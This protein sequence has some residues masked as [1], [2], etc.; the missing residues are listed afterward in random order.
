MSSVASRLPPGPR[1]PL[2]GTRREL[3]GGVVAFETEIRRFD[4]M[5]EHRI[6]GRIVAPLG[7]FGAQALAAAAGTSQREARAGRVEDTLVERPLTLPRDDPTRRRNARPAAT[8]RVVIGCGTDAGWRPFEL[9]SRMGRQAP[10]RHVSGRLATAPSARDAEAT[11]LDIDRCRAR[12]ASSPVSEFYRRLAHA[13][14]ELGTEFR[15]LE[16]LWLG[17]GEALGVVRLPADRQAGA[18][19]PHPVMLDACFQVVAA[20]RPTG[21]LHEDEPWLTLG[22]KRLRLPQPFPARVIC[23]ALVQPPVD[24]DGETLKADLTWYGADGRMVGEALGVV[25]RR[26]SRSRLVA[27]ATGVE[28]LLYEVKWRNAAPGSPKVADQEQ[29]PEPGAWLLFAPGAGEAL[30][31]ARDLA[32]ALASRGHVAVLASDRRLPDSRAVRIEPLER[33]SW[34][35]ALAAVSADGPCRGVV[36]LA[37]VSGSEPEAAVGFSETAEGLLRSAQALSQASS[38]TDQEQLPPL[39]FVTRGGQM[40]GSEWARGLPG[41]LLWGLGR[42]LKCESGRSGVRLVDLDPGTP[43]ADLLARELVHADGETDIAFRGGRRLTA[44]LLPPVSDTVLPDH[45]TFRLTWNT[46]GVLEPLPTEKVKPRPLAAGEVRIAVEAAGLAFHDVIAAMGLAG[47]DQALGAEMCGRVLEVGPEVMGIS[48]GDRVVGLAR[49]SFGTEVVTGAEL[50][51]PAPPGLASVVCATLPGPFATAALAFELAGLQAGDRVLIHA[52]AGGVGHAAMQLADAAGLQ[53]LATASDPKQDYLRSLGV[54]HVF[55]SRTTAFGA[56]ILE[57]TRGAGVAMVLNSLTGRGFIEASLSCLAP[58]GCFVELGKRGIWSP[59]RMEAMRPDIR[60]YAFLLRGIHARDSTRVPRVLRDIVNRISAGELKPL[61]YRRW[62][63]AQAG[64]AFAEMRSARHVGRIV[65]T[66]SALAA[67]RLRDDRS[68]LVTGAFHG[69]G[70]RIAGWLRDHGAAAIVMNG[71]RPPSGDAESEMEALR[72]RG[73]TV[74]AVVADLA[75]PETV[76]QVLAGVA[77]SA[78]PPLGGIVHCPGVVSDTPPP[79][80][81][82][83]SLERVL[84]RKV[85]AAWNLHCATLD[86]DLD[87]FVLFSGFSGVLGFPGPPG[88]AAAN[89]FLDQLALYR[90]AMGLAGQ[91]IQWGPLSGLPDEAGESPAHA[92]AEAGFWAI[93]P[94]ASLEALSRLIRRDSGTTAVVSADWS[95]VANEFGPGARVLAGLYPRANRDPD[96]VARKLE[97]PDGPPP[98]GTAA[99]LEVVRREVR[100]LL[101]WRVLPARGAR[102]AE[103]GMDSLLVV[104]L[105]RRLRRALEPVYPVPNAVLFDHA[106][107]E[108]LA[109]GIACG[110]DPRDA[111]RGAGRPR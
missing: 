78:L 77:R 36:H 46:E 64:S 43:S 79:S 5:P 87:L 107:P 47:R 7:L 20:A 93:T 71:C 30:R 106:T 50:V 57:A 17:P 96:P 82:W 25:L 26:A 32:A 56:E 83:E 55:D 59:E 100:S 63:L 61:P 84:G 65:L 13:G 34:R 62:P 3:P 75:D 14:V 42:A 97:M 23:H 67:G 90:R 94:E 22:W 58:G 41:S 109:R 51:A 2:L 81:S 49:G 9:F 37:A 24:R 8:L 15:A 72:E 108:G 98:E 88:E 35:A 110:F 29:K 6:F 89:A 91:A 104:E 21:G 28:R 105:G 92:S 12:L 18:G 74:R 54:Q 99:L 73:A 38:S 4:W 69:A 86:L 45:G 70:L 10:V 39:W 19:A 85:S 76:A 40:V 101:G 102:F 66:P 111:R 11:R 27:A 60:Y 103:L 53:V 33:D 16:A 48:P 44:R 1:H 80:D 31:F 95:A 52:A 68:Y